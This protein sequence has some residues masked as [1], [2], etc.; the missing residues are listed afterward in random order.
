M[1]NV[2]MLSVVAPL[3]GAPLYGRLLALHTNIRLG[4]KSLVR[5]K[6]R[7][8]RTMIKYGLE[9]FKIIE[10]RLAVMTRHGSQIENASIVIYFTHVS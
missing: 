6:T 9:K 2:I 5:T 8:L 4:W 10:A 3:S 7:L 1:Q